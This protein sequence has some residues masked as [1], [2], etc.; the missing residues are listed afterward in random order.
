MRGV[1]GIKLMTMVIDDK[2]TNHLFPTFSLITLLHTHT[3]DNSSYKLYL[4]SALHWTSTIWMNERKE[5]I[6]FKRH[7]FEPS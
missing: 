1:A 5:I 4:L 7:K 3:A 2:K 6:R